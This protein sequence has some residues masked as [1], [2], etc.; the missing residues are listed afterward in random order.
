MISGNTEIFGASLRQISGKVEVLDTSA[1]SQTG[2]AVRIEG[3]KEMAPLSYTLSSR[4]LVDVSRANNNASGCK[5]LEIGEDYV[6]AEGS[7]GT[8]PGT[9]AW[10]SG[11]ISF[12]LPYTLEIGKTYSV[13]FDID[14]IEQM[15]EFSFPQTITVNIGGGRSAGSLTGLGTYHIT[16]TFTL[17]QT[18]SNLLIYTNSCKIRA[19]NILVVEGSDAT[20]TPFVK[21]LDSV[22]VKRYGKNL[23]NAS[24][25]E[26]AAKYIK[27]DGTMTGSTGYVC[28]E[29]FIPVSHLRGQKITINHPV[30]EKSATTNARTYAFYTA[31]S[32]TSYISGS[33]TRNGTVMVPWAANYMRIGIPKD[34]TA[35]GLTLDYTINDIQIELGD[36]ETALEPYQEPVVING[37]IP[38]SNVNTLIST[39]ADALITA[40]FLAE[41]IIDTYADTDKLQKISIDRTGDTKF[42]GY[43]ISQKATIE[44]IDKECLCGL[45]S[46]DMITVFFNEEKISPVFY[47]DKVSRDEKSGSLKVEAQDAL[48]LATQHIVNE[49]DLPTTYTIGDLADMVGYALEMKVVRPDLDEFNISYEEGANLEGTETY[50][51]LLNYIAEATQTI[52]FVNRD[53]HIV[54]KRLGEIVDWTIDR[55]QYFELTNKNATT[56]TGVCS[57]TELGDNYEYK[58]ADGYIQ[59]VRDNPLWNMREDVDVLVQNAVAA[60]GGLTINQFNCSWRG[61][62]LVEPGDK[63]ALITKDNNTIYS[64]LINDKIEYG[65]GYKQTSEWE[66][67]TQEKENTNPATLGEALK[68]TYAKVDKTSKKIEIVAS[69]LAAAQGEIAIL[70]VSTGEISGSV[71]SYQQ[72]TNEAFDSL[73][74][75]VNTLTNKVN[76]TMT[77]EEIRFEIQSELS[78]GVE[79]VRTT[80]KGYSFD[81]EGLSITSSE[82]NLST[83]ITEDGMTVSVADAPVLEANNEGVVAIDLHARTFLKIGD[84]SRLENMPG[85]NRT[86]CFWTGG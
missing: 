75:E 1:S 40:S 47:I 57:A 52:Y 8:T 3:C 27:S 56:L 34:Y 39:N 62:Y 31:A 21:D 10:S 37:S 71:S 79:K 23:F 68:Q 14:Y 33:T 41:S 38:A 81:D 77:S 73:N 85:M 45:A 80:T 42:F 76:A 24:A 11:Y 29:A 36:T 60:V 4:N 82:N 28:V 78:N 74:E 44:L 54:F 65:G 58:T 70:Q 83:K 2:G 26:L 30:S 51:E 50:R 20:Y 43:G 17:N 63:I 6:I 16:R 72:T 12:P 22:E 18:T 25:Y 59:Y 32:D 9:A 48:Y 15:A 61:N 84:F 35:D 55:T 86:A 67:G 7:A 5:I 69:D 13:S 19:Y 66:C 46:E 53:N 49:L 64:Y